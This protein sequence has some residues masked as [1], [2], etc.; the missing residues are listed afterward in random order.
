MHTS[1]SLN[2]ACLALVLFVALTGQAFS[3]VV[4]VGSC[5]SLVN[6]ATIQ[7][8][9]N[10]VP[11]GS[12]IKVC[13]GNYHEQVLITQKVTLEGFVSSN[14][15]AAVLLPPSTGLVQ[16]TTDARGGVAA[17]I[18]VQGT[19]GP[20]V[21][22]N[23]IVDGT[24]NQVSDC[25]SDVRG[26]VY[27]DASGT[28]NRVA[29]RNEVPG[30]TPSGCQSGQGI[31]VE[32]DSGQTAAL[33]VE[34]SSV[35]NYNKNGIVARYAGASLTAT[36]NYVRGN[37]VVAS[38]GAA[39]NG[40]EIA[41]GATG[42]VTSNTVVENVYGDTTV[43]TSSDILLFDTAENSSITVSTNTAGN[44]NIPIGLETD[45]AGEGDGVTVSSNKVFG[46]TTNDGIDVCTNGNTIKSN[47]IT[48]SAQSA[49]HFDASCGSTGSNNSASG[50]IFVESYCAGILSDVA[51]TGNTIGAE[52]YDMVPFT[53]ASSTSSCTIPAGANNDVIKIAKAK[54]NNAHTF[55]P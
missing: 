47:T 45:T 34:N 50:N 22:S 33:L 3:S 26:I 40:I 6:F 1:R 19:A 37:G 51:T 39:Q 38:G 2:L 48:D 16:N 18:L 54:G 25:G 55:M 31:F 17:Q 46:A 24:G 53:Q 8:A 44:S 15:D 5:S 4:A 10:A 43:A 32:A 52:T 7:Q 11:S 13:P 14:N 9:V 36:G 27:Q 23:L 30:D 21:I 28:V 20:V 41:F 12:T 49:L 42:K 29:V 35:H